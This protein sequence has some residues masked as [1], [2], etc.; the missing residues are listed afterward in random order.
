M[1]K[2][3]LKLYKL[4]SYARFLLDNHL[5]EVVKED[6]K[7]AK[8]VALPLLNLFSH[9]SEEERFQFLKERAAD[10]LTELA[11]DKAVEG[12]LKII[13][14]LKTDQLE[15]IP[16]EG[17]VVDDTVLTYNVKKHTFFHFLPRYTS[18]PEEII[19][20]V[21]EI[22]DYYTY[23]EYLA[24]QA[25]TEINTAILAQS[26]ENFRSLAEASFE[27]IVI[28]SNFKILEA[29]HVAA[30][31]YG[32]S[33]DELIGSHIKVF[34]TEE[35]YPKILEKV[36]T[37]SET[38]YET[39]GKRKDGTVFP[40]EIIGRQMQYKGE[41]VRVIGIRDI[42][43]RKKKDLQLQE[44]NQALHQRNLQLDEIHQELQ[45][46]NAELDL[47]VKERTRALEE[48][49]NRF[50][51]LADSVPQ[52]VWIRDSEGN[53]EY[54]NEKWRKYT[55]LT[56][57]NSNT[58]LG[59]SP[60]HPEDLQKAISE[61][62]K[63]REEGTMYEAVY[64]FRR[65]SDQMYRWHI[66]R[67]LPMKNEHGK[68]IKWFGTLTDIHDQK[69]TE[70][71]LKLQAHVLNNMAE[72]VSLVDLDGYILYTNK[73]EDEMFGYEEG[74]LI[75]KH[76]TIQNNLPQEE[77]SSK[78]NSIIEYLKN[79]DVWKGEWENLKKD[80]TPFTTYCN[81]STLQLG[82]RKLFVCV[83]QDI[84]SEK[85]NREALAY[86]SKLNKTITDNATS[87]LFLMDSK[88][89]CRFM[90]P[91][92]EKMFGFSFEE[93]SAKPLHYMI[94][95]HRPDGSPYPMEECPIDRALPDN[96]R[97]RAH[98]DVFFRKD[99]TSFP[100]SCAASPIFENDKPVAT[101]IEV[102][103]ITEEKQFKETILTKNE[104]LT[105]INN[106]LDNFIY[107]A[108]HDL[109]A[110]ISNIEGLIS[111]LKELL[112]EKEHFDEEYKEIITF[113]FSSINKFRGT[114]QDLTD[115]SK[116]Q[117]SFGENEV[118]N[119]VQEEVKNIEETIQQEIKQKGALITLDVDAAPNITFTKKN[120]RSI[121]YNL[122][123]NAIKYSH[124]NRPPV[125]NISTCTSN[126]FIL[127]KIQDNG[128]GIKQEHISRIFEMFRRLHDHVD[129]S[130]VG[131][132]IVRRM[133]DNAGGKIEVESKVGEGTTFKLYFKQKQ[134]PHSIQ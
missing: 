25:Y 108:S 35:E 23:K 92:G 27:G 127:L 68:A 73:A 104:E 70:E 36:K 38:S 126:G 60:I 100:V 66:A 67:A 134:L 81:I 105:K 119:N 78:V 89:F 96:S 34:T 55:G 16:K 93:I 125:V 116:A 8:E 121:L 11:E 107:T 39:L 99:G 43:E 54:V 122:I 29:N 124:P 97:I 69:S 22:E 61:W 102:R 41:S 42:T 18:D 10:I 26:E 128:L 74:E 33:K 103:D 88:G 64:R 114:I 123:N 50:K 83:Q 56:L 51:L 1:N 52:I 87:C 59:D 131:L 120:F 45:K 115:I 2:K 63:A 94:H 6:L 4:Q 62:V 48:S 90:N 19:V 130:G 49:Q 113:I 28:H 112:Q 72:G 58:R 47:R 37:L 111:T 76:V 9:L 15:N 117:K 109:R 79:N 30:E 3:L 80:G 12:A 71:S 106:D 7:R 14:K 75:G 95:H 21:K 86:Q 31:M 57:G 13:E 82:E 24:F 110:P 118:I 98:E 32:Y 91:A 85:K 20:L 65:D 77:N 133:I 101:I 53:L 5:D 40:V 46:T 129:G 17:V 84:T 132:Y 44:T